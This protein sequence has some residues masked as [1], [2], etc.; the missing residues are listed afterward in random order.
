M[1]VLVIS[2]AH[3]ILIGVYE[4]GKLIQ[5]FTQDGKSS[6]IIPKIF[7]QILEQHSIKRVFY[8]NAPGSYMAIKVAYVFLKTISIVKNI[9][10]YASSGFN[11]NQNSPIKALGKK[12]FIYK[13][14]E[15]NIECIN[16]DEKIE[17]F[18]LPP[19]LDE[20]IFSTNNL[21]QYNL[22]AV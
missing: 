14:G 12:Y 1:D 15:I 11:F 16:E 5:T 22:P 17:N 13:N 10:L 18:T 6:D 19:L 7:S 20:T 4:D 3:P 2:V 9:P 8:V 21:P